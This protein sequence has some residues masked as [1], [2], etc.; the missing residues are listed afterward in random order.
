MDY[1]NNCCEPAKETQMEYL[2]VDEI[3][4]KYPQQY[5]MVEDA[6]LR[7]IGRAHV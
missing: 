5:A 6:N 2:K 1:F 4:A 3:K 7:K